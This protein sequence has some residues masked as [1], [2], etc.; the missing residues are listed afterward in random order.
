M[1]PPDFSI[2]S[3]FK[4]TLAPAT[5]RH[6]G[7][8]SLPPR[9]RCCGRLGSD[10]P[11]T[12]SA[13][14]S[15]APGS[16]LWARFLPSL[17]SSFLHC[18]PVCRSSGYVPQPVVLM[19]SLSLII[20]GL[21][22]GVFLCQLRLTQ[23]MTVTAGKNAGHG[24]PLGFRRL[25]RLPGGIIRRMDQGPLPASLGVRHPPVRRSLLLLPSPRPPPG[26]DR[27]DHCPADPVS[28]RKIQ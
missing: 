25:H 26:A 16:W 20:G 17:G 2:S 9:A 8:S 5:S 11:S 21:Y 4:R 3:I 14:A 18:A 15:S 13:P 27:L 10:T 22:A 12:A 7:S 1:A 24:R 19:S 28:S 23:A 6:P